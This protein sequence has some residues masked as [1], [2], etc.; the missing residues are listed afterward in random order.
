MTDRLFILGPIEAKPYN[1]P[2]GQWIRTPGEALEAIAE[3]NKPEQPKA[4]MESAAALLA[5]ARTKNV[6]PY[7]LALE[8]IASHRLVLLQH[9]FK[10][11]I[12]GAEL[13]ELHDLLDVVTSFNRSD[14]F[15]GGI[16]D[17][18]DQM[19]V[20]YRGDFTSLLVP[21]AWFEPRPA[22]GSPDW[23]GFQVTDFGQTLR[24]GEYEVAADAVLYEFDSVFRQE[25]KRRLLE[26]DDSFGGALRR[27]R[28]QRGLR[29]GQFPSLS[30]KEVARIER[31]EVS[32]PHRSTLLTLANRLGVEP[33]AIAE[34]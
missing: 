22:V 20:L 24:M 23:T 5:S 4:L 16:V 17:P 26:E 30:A 32:K 25:A 8:P 18:D 7:L 1:F 21:F 14:L 33:D 19:L 34:Y 15:I 3:A 31:G 29:R 2:D 12:A 28:L 6:T 11:I 9:Q 27:L 10:G 13:L